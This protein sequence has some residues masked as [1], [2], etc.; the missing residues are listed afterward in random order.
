MRFL[1]LLR[2]NS[3]VLVLAAFLLIVPF[4]FPSLAFI[5]IV[6]EI[7]IMALYAVSLN[8]LIGYT[9]F[10]SF[11][12]AAFFGVGSY[13]VGIMLQKLSASLPL[14]IPV[15][16]LCGMILSGIV[17]LVIGYFCTR[18]TAIYFAFLTLAFSQIIY[19]VIIKWENFTGGD[20]G[21]VG[22]IPRAPI[23]LFGLS[24]DMTSPFNLYFLIVIAVCV[25]FFIIKII[26]D[27]PF[28]WVIRAIRDNSERINFLGINVRRYTIIVI[29]IS[30]IFTGLAG[31]L[32]A[33]H[34]SGSYPDHAHWTKS[35]EPIFMIMVGGMRV[36]TGPILGAIIVTELSAY[37]SSYIGLWGLIFGAFLVVFLMISRQGVL[38]VLA[39]R[40]G[41]IKK[42]K[43]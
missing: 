42:L 19:A 29:I 36:F 38:D 24:I 35:A 21:L 2:A 41:L 40:T 22:G 8:L 3:W 1:G 27:S 26:T 34:V 9:G 12:H 6:A 11:G 39:L 31:G 23:N 43:L 17:A 5:N 20:Q 25:S 30:G 13:T 28:G 4:L 10:V 14:A 32:M 7:L 16:L 33:L 18:L 15:A 37:L